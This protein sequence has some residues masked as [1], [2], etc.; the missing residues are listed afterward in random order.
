MYEGLLARD[1]LVLLPNGQIVS[2]S[3][4]HTIRLW[5]LENT[6]ATSRVL[7]VADPSITA[8]AL[9]PIHNLLVAGDA[10][11]RLHWLKLPESLSR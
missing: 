3:R 4:D 1:S 5:D 11:G 10:S 6:G 8:L 2:G 7:F 9:D